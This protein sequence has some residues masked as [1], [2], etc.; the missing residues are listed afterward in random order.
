M[1]IN[2]SSALVVSQKALAPQAR[3][4]RW[5]LAAFGPVDFT[6]ALREEDLAGWYCIKCHSSVL[7][8]KM[9]MGND[10]GG[11][12]GH[13][14]GTVHDTPEGWGMMFWEPAER[15]PWV[16]EDMHLNR[17]GSF[18]FAENPMTHPSLAWLA[19]D[20]ARMKDQ[21]FHGTGT[22]HDD[23]SPF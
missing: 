21:G 9:D 18:R 1:M 8:S 5:H 15:L 20:G 4:C 11:L 22:W 2:P 6:A 17:A 10:I 13:T 19:T 23:T 3:R 14:W 7:W 16:W 12:C